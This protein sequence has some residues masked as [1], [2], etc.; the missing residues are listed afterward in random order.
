MV[1][2]RTR[3]IY[4]VDTETT[5]VDLEAGHTLF[6]VALVNLDDPLDRHQWFFALT[7]DEIAKADPKCLTGFGNYNGRLLLQRNVIPPDYQA[8]KRAINQ[9]FDYLDGSILAAVNPTFDDKFLAAFVASYGL[10]RVWDYH[11]LDIWT[12]S[13]PIIGWNR[14]S[15]DIMGALGL[16]PCAHTAMG[17]ALVERDALIMLRQMA[18]ERRR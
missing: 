1:H 3:R 8:R 16:P 9:V 11:L 18:R 13:L 17:D 10:Q 4:V 2:P 7:M 6:E 12:Y 15:R 14:G 5:G